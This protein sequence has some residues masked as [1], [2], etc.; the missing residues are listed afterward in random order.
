[1]QYPSMCGKA[2]LGLE[3]DLS[4]WMM[5]PAEEMRQTWLT[6]LTEGLV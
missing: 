2:S 6:V 3:M 1:M 4:S 5:W